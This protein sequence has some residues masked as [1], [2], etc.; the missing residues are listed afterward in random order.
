MLDVDWLRSEFGLK[1]SQVA[2]ELL[3]TQLV[4]AFEL[5]LALFGTDEGE[6]FGIG[7]VFH[8]GMVVVC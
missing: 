8:V 1:A 4:L 6:D 5:T 2:S 7:G 3:E